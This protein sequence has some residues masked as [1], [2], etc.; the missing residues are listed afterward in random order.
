MG[1]EEIGLNEKKA[2]PTLVALRYVCICEVK[3]FAIP[4]PKTID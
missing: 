4:K 1:K 2:F 3:V